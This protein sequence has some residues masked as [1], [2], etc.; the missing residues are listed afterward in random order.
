MPH[1]NYGYLQ[2]PEYVLTTANHS[3][4]FKIICQVQQKMA[5]KAMSRLNGLSLCYASV[6]LCNVLCY[7]LYSVL[8]V[9]CNITVAIKSLH[10]QQNRMR[11]CLH[12]L[13]KNDGSQLNSIKLFNRQYSI[14]IHAL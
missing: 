2:M 6:P 1:N 14:Q 7:G 10:N 13:H 5:L 8:L 11:L 4:T 3:L 9:K 12:K